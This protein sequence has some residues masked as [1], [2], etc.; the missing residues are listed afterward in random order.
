[1]IRAAL[2]TTAVFCIALAGC[3]SSNGAS[4]RDQIWAVGSSTVYP[5]AKAVSEQFAQKHPNFKSPRIESLGTGGGFKVFC[6]G[7]GANFPDI[8]DASRRIKRS[9]YDICS[10]NGVGR[11]VEIQV[12]LD[13]I[14][15][16]ESL[17]GAKIPLTALDVYKALAATPFGK[18]QTAKTWK[19]VNPALPAEPIKVYGPPSTSGTRDAFA[20]LIMTRG[21]DVD[22]AMR[23]LGDAKADQHRKICTTIRED[24]AYV[25]SGENDNLIVQKIEADPKAIGIFGYSFMEENKDRLFANTVNGVSPTYETISDFTYPGA[26]PLFLYIK[27][28][29]VNAVPGIKEYVSEFLAAAGAEGYLKKQGLVLSPANVQA[30]SAAIAKDMKPFD[31]STLQ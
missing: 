5:F 16:A 1:M 23:D 17:K 22:S 27:S 13:G 29:H 21:C 20:E 9:E 3:D 25:D 4:A 14:A 2:A 31:P 30:K 8:E 15:L 28:A 12:G 19:D 26:R 6:D 11:I 24:G 10:K 7:A 18:P